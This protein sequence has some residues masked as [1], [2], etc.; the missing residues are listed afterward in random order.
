MVK[1]GCEVWI[2]EYGRLEA[3]SDID[4]K[5][6]REGGNVPGG[7]P[8]HDDEMALALVEGLGETLRGAGEVLGLRGSEEPWSESVET[9]IGGGW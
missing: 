2:W 8:E 4:D 9:M 3:G 1:R 7:S 6:A 5:S